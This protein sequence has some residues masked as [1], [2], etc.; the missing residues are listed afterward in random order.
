MVQFNILKGTSYQMTTHAKAAGS[1]SFDVFADP[2]INFT[3]DVPNFIFLQY[4][5]SPW[6]EILEICLANT[7]IIIDL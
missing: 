4:Q 5:I 3:D 2:W 1:G 6:N 7:V